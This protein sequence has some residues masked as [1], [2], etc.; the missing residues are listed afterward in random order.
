LIYLEF[1]QT[2]HGFDLFLPNVSMP[3]QVAL[4]DVDRFLG[5]LSARENGES[6][7]V[8]EVLRRNA[9]SVA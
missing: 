9:A 7:T 5:L 1:P 3:G 2:E 4:Y 8:K 6:A